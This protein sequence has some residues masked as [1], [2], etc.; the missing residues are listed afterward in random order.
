MY[1]YG[2]FQEINKIQSHTMTHT[3]KL[4]RKGWCP[5]RYINLEE[6]PKRSTSSASL[7]SLFPHMGGMTKHDSFKN[8]IHSLIDVAIIL[9]G[10]K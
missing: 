7:G 9:N 4:T 10:T 3:H 1:S 2:S 6:G 5:K 8:K